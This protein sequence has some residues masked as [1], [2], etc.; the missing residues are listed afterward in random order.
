MKTLQRIL[1]LAAISALAASAWAHEADNFK[2]VPSDG[3]IGDA[4]GSA[5]SID[6]TV[7]LVA[8]PMADGVG[9]D[10]GAVYVYN[11]DGVAWNEIA[12]LTASDAAAGAHFGA[13]VALNGSRLVVGAPGANGGDGSAYAFS[14]DGA[15]WSEDAVLSPAGLA[16]GAAF[17]S[18]VAIDGSSAVIGAPSASAAYVFVDAGGWSQEAAL[19]AL[20]SVPGDNF[21]AGV[22][23]NGNFIAVG[24]PNGTGVIANSG[25]VHMFSR[26]ASL[27]SE[28]QT[29]ILADPTT[30]DR[31]GAALDMYNSIELLIGIP[32]IDLGATDTGG[33]QRFRLEGG[34]WVLKN[35]YPGRDADDRMGESIALYD[36]F[37]V[38]GVTGDDDEAQDAGTAFRFLKNSITP[39][40]IYVGSDA[41]PDAAFG[42]AVDVSDIW[43]VN[44]SPAH[45]GVGSAYIHSAVQAVVLPLLGSGV[46]PDILSTL[47]GPVIGETWNSSVDLTL[48]PDSERTRLIMKRNPSPAPI[49]TMFGEIFFR[50]ADP[51]VLMNDALGLHSLSVPNNP[52]ILDREFTLMCVVYGAAIDGFP[53]LALTNGQTVTI[54][55]TDY[56]VNEEGDED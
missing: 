54:G 19:G 33:S 45:G 9:A 24:A 53:I 43:A 3:A 44:G 39:L 56:P 17:G 22:T 20:G 46:N 8:S 31:F 41:E 50:T 16:A 37:N 6:G 40:E 14:F 25:T 42:A 18:S 51:V 47:S 30:G 52:A 28:D 55:T 36:R 10:S 5:V 15:V 27:W 23:I 11:F 2:L 29:L 12:K 4:F 48:Y 32:G 7:A 26:S 34:S 1:P 35:S 21:G 13:S 38:M 49:M